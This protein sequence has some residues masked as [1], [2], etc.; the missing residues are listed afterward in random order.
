M[1]SVLTQCRIHTEDGIQSWNPNPQNT[2]QYLLLLDKQQ[3][4]M[5][6]ERKRVATATKKEPGKREMMPVG[7]LNS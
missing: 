6:C 5:N 7:A 3:R 4:K 1:A 2:L